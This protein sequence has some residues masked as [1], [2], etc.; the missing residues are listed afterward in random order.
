MWFFLYQSHI[1][2]I[3]NIN[4]TL[5]DTDTGIFNLDF[6]LVIHKL[7]M[8]LESLDQNS[9]L[10]HHLK[11]SEEPELDPQKTNMLCS[12]KCRSQAENFGTM[13]KK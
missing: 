7:T 4:H 10:K 3:S 2:N 11:K 12:Y 1:A 13:K 6:Y 9:T 5:H 8:E